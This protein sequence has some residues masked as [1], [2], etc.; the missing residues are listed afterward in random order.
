M[1][2]TETSHNRSVKSRSNVGRVSLSPPV[3]VHT[4]SLAELFQ[5]Q[6]SDA[7][8]G[9]TTAEATR[10]LAQHGPNTLAQARQRSAL[11][12]CLAQFR[13][14]IVALLVVAT[15]IA[16]AMGE[17]IEAVA[18]LVVIILNAGIGFL[19]EWKAEQALSALQK[20]SVRVAQVIRDG[21]RSEIPAV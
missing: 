11:S 13:S 3:A 18:I 14:L 2:I 1:L 5:L 15:V 6:Q 7:A 12:I 20:Q 19:T 21:A 17:N 16:F 4:L 8:E 10:R 9:L